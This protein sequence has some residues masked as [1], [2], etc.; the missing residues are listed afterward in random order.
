MRQPL[1]R[2]LCLSFCL[3]WAASSALALEFSTFFTR[4]Y[5]GKGEME[6]LSPEDV[7]LGPK[8]EFV[9]ADTR[10]NRLQ[11]LKPDGTFQRVLIPRDVPLPADPL[12]DTGKNTDAAKD[13][14]KDS[15][16]EP[17]KELT[18]KEAAKELS[19]KEAAKIASGTMLDKPVGLALDANRRLY[20][21]SS[22]NHTIFVINFPDG[23]FITKI[24]KPGRLQGEINTPLDLDVRADGL[25]AVA[26]SGN[27]RVQIFDGTGT[28]LREIHYKEETAKKELRSLAPRGV[29]WLPSGELVV[30]YPTF[31]QIV[32][33]DLQGQIIWRYGSMGSGKGQ[34][35]EPAH[36]AL[37]RGGNLMV[38][39]GKNN[40]IVEVSPTGQ[41]V[42]HHSGRGTMP[43]KLYTPRGLVLTNDDVLCVIDQ[44]NNRVSL[45]KPGKA[46]TFVREA[47][48]LIENDR[49]DEAYPKIE[50]VLSFDPSNPE[51]RNLMVN[52]LHFFGDR[53]YKS[54]DFDKAEEFYRR[55]LLYQPND[56]DVQPKLDDIFWAT[57]KDLIMRAVFG[58]IGIIAALMLLWVVKISFNRFVFGHA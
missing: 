21:S 27:K 44:G 31:H 49:W 57:N 23:K 8:G 3:V 51:A 50:Q 24:G 47:K 53:S 42:R 28:F 41:Y 18:K 17:L 43:G 9:V 6:F 4:G 25:L 37:G 20:I 33:W 5:E 35:N 56:M 38:S 48:K 19:K 58:I 40:R 52:S 16:K 30:S 36:I 10:N 14:A 34:M 55:V 12:S 46:D 54:F 32:C 7:I 11:V 15:T 13:P 1:P 26:D 2:L 29:L 22:G 45:F 39:D